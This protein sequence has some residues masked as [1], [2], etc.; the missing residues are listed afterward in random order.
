MEQY[1]KTNLAKAGWRGDRCVSQHDA[2][3]LWANIDRSNDYRQLKK[4][5]FY[6]HLNGSHHLTAKDQLHLQLSPRGF[7]FYPQSFLI[8]NEY[9]E[10][11]KENNY[12]AALAMLKII[13]RQIE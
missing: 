4:G 1:M 7:P 11:A 13:S 10:F 8:P 2:Q 3:L 12:I 9:P 5:Q 6:N